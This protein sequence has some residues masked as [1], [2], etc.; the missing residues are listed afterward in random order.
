MLVGGLVAVLFAG[1]LQLGLALH[2]RAT[3]IDAAAE[4]ARLAA[5][6]DRSAEDGRART[7]ELVSAAVSQEYAR[8]VTATTV[9]RDGVEIVEVTVTAA[10]PVVGL[11]G[12]AE[13]V[14]VTGHALKEVR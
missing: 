7:V 4:G 8:D 11:L 3:L 14:T 5:R 9:L 1:A 13:R 2:V 6:E 10:L 12:P